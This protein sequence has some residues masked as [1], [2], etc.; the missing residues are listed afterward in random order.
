MFY[1]S[2]AHIF[3][4]HLQGNGITFRL[5]WRGRSL[6][7]AT[8]VG[9]FFLST[10]KKMEAA[11][12][13]GWEIGRWSPGHTQEDFCH[14]DDEIEKSTAYSL[15]CHIDDD[16][17][18]EQESWSWDLEIVSEDRLAKE[19]FITDNRWDTHILTHTSLTSPKGPLVR[20][21]AVKVGGKLLLKTL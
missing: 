3:P 16:S 14:D 8:L 7:V 2:F 18:C 5:V 21:K 10:A 9:N 13:A 15:K 12:P 1:W 20:L 19:V 6:K 11:G 4:F 17:V